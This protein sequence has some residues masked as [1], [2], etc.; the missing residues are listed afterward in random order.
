MKKTLDEL[1]AS[2]VCADENHSNTICISLLATPLHGF[3]LAQVDADYKLQ[4]TKKV[5]KELE[6]KGKGYKKRLDDLHV[7]LTKHLEQ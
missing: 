1:R 6:M 4:D 7:S 3:V 5:L 2:E